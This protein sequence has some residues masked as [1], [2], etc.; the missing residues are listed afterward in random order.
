MQEEIDFS[1]GERGKFFRENSQ[2]NAPVYLEPD[3]RKYVDS[4]AAKEGMDVGTIVNRLLKKE[5]QL[6]KEMM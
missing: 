6:A 2:L 3:I 1:K 5:M 4:I